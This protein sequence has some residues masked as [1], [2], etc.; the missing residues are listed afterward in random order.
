MDPQAIQ[1]DIIDNQYMLESEKG[2]NHV[3]SLRIPVGQKVTWFN[4]EATY[5]TVTHLQERLFN[6][7]NLKQLDKFTYIFEKPGR[8][9]VYCRN[10]PQTLIWIDV[11][12]PNPQRCPSTEKID[13]QAQ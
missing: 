6:S 9:W 4:H 10:H 3:D 12:D 8:Y 5:H 11:Y 7:G 1:I 2:L 13:A